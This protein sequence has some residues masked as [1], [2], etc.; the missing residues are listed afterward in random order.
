MNRLPILIVGAGPTGLMM[1][2]ELARHNIPFRIID[3]KSEPTQGS[4]ATWIQTRTLEIFDLLGMAEHFIKIGH[5]CDAINFYAHGKQVTNL[6]LSQID[7]TYPFILM[8]PQSKIEQLL[9]KKLVAEK[10]Q[11]E[12]SLELIDIKKTNNGMLSTIQLSNGNTENIISDW[13]IACDGAN[14]TVREKYK[15]PFPGEHLLEQFMVADAK[16]SSF[17]PA[18]QIHVF[19]DEGTIFPDKGTLFAAFPRGAKEYRLNANLYQEQ[20]RKNFTETEVR[21]IVADRTYGNYIVENV[22]WISP[23]WIHSKIADRMHQDAVFL[24]GDAAH[25]HSPAGGQGMN[26]GIQDAFNL[27]WKL[28]LVIQGKSNAS[29]LDSYQAERYPIIKN[30]VTQT[31]FFT[32]M[33]L[34]DKSFFEKLKKFSQKI[35]M[36]P[37]LSREIGAELTQIKIQYGKSPIIDYKLMPDKQAPQPGERAPD[38]IIQD[39]E[40]LYGYFH[41][42]VHTI[43]VFTGN[44][45]TKNDLAKINELNKLAIEKFTGLVNILIVT[46]DSLSDID[47][48]IFDK[49]GSIH[50]RYHVKKS[51]VYIIRPDNYIAYYSNDA[52]PES[53]AQF[54]QQYLLTHSSK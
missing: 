30:V 42:T 19:F 51:A 3:K 52:D 25:I 49:T 15:I 22:S 47:N 40:K 8:L 12:R 24:V 37:A 45:P 44:V 34:F 18:N 31:E 43:L 53:I 36:Q 1:A 14:S 17:L 50:Q 10:I 7:S 13:I 23:F 4:N 39:T 41:N 35:S 6:P 46:S 27:A 54:L 26:T 21:E 38:V 16:M 29:L 20:P 33:V 9:N 32:K 48:I 2:C 28:A 11:V 5:K